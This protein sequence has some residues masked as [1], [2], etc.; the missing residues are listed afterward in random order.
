MSQSIVDYATKGASD[1][2]ISDE[3]HE[4]VEVVLEHDFDG[5]V[6]LGS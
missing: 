1:A 4:E 5:D 6:R 2:T 3:L